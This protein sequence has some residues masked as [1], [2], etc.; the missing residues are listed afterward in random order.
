MT[1]DKMIKQLTELENKLGGETEVCM[2]WNNSKYGPQKID[3]IDD[4]YYKF[5]EDEEIE[6]ITEL[7]TSKKEIQKLN[8]IVVLNCDQVKYFTGT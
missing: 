5:D 4:A 1:I 2:F 6:W 7:P 8:K 3:L